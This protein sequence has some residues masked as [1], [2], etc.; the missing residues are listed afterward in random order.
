MSRWSRKIWE[1][2][3]SWAGKV[4]S[5][6][7]APNYFRDWIHLR[8]WRSD[9]F[10]AIKEFLRERLSLGYV[11]YPNHPTNAM[12][13]WAKI[14]R[15]LRETPYK[16]V[17]IVIIGQDP[18]YKKG[19][20]DGLA[21]S[22]PPNVRPGMSSLS[23]IFKEYQSDLGFPQPRTGDLSTWARNGILLLNAV[24]TVEEGTPK[25]HYKINGKQLWQELTAEIIQKLNLKDKLVFILWG[26]AAQEWRY[27][28]DE[29]KHLV[30]TGAHP[31]PRNLTWTGGNKPQFRGG[32]Y[33]SKACEYLQLDTKIWRLP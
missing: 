16:D 23:L 27:L 20:A 31:S 22:M 7:K 25:A 17:K 32:K 3:R 30:L 29:K 9:N 8:F 21:F 11:I 12:P 26:N 19:Q 5:N 4:S 28:V 2:Y 1:R 15:C 10:S 18:Y 14:F 33:F 24:W 6:K 13:H